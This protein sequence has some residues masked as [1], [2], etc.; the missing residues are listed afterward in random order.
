M[1]NSSRGWLSVAAIA[2]TLSCTPAQATLPDQS[3]VEGEESKRYLIFDPTDPYTPVGS[4]RGELQDTY[5][6]LVT[7]RGGEL[8]HTPLD[9]PEANQFARS[10]HFKLSL[11]GV[12][13]GEVVESR[14]GEFAVHERAGSDGEE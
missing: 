7:D 9:P 1:R 8:I 5:A 3:V 2:V 11:D 6:L 10:G 13:S 14:T 12:L 4:L